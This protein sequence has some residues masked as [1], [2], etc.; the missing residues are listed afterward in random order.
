MGQHFGKLE[1]HGP[2]T[3]VNGDPCLFDADDLDNGLDGTGAPSEEPLRLSTQTS[4]G[5]VGLRIPYI[6][7]TGS[8]AFIFPSMDK[9]YDQAS[10]SLNSIVY[11]FLQEG[12]EISDDLCMGTYTCDWIPALDVNTEQ[13]EE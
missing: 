9:P 5:V 4:S 12:K 10:F 13:D 3:D 8:H 11:F 7:T 2:Y 1:Q 6:E